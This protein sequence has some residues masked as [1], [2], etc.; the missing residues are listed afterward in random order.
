MSSKWSMGL[1]DKK[2]PVEDYDVICTEC[3]KEV[4]RKESYCPYCKCNIVISKK[5][6]ILKK[7]LNEEVQENEKQ[8]IGKD[9]SIKK[10]WKNKE[11]VQLKTDAIAVLFKKRGYED[12][13]F[14]EFDNLTIEGYKMVLMESV[15][16]TDAGPIDIQIGNYYYFQKETLIK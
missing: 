6:S 8:L 13:F 16:V 1:F 14:T 12:E 7:E 11:I 9:E 15:K 10:L 3:G 4:S 5:K 2:P